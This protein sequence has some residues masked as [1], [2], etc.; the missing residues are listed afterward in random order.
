M[1][2]LRTLGVALTGLTLAF[3]ANAETG[4][5]SDTVLFGQI[6]AL[7]GPAARLG[8]GVQSGILAAFAEAN[9]A[10]GVHGRQLVLESRDDG[11]EPDR[12]VEH[13]NSMIEEDKYFSLIGTVGTPTNK[14]LQ[15][16]ATEAGFPLIGPFTGAGFLRNPELGNLYNVRGSYDA[17]AEQ[18]IAHLVEEL[19][20]TNIA[21]LYQD[22]SFGRAGLSGVN[23]ALTKRGM[24]LAAEG[25]Y[26]RN[27]T[28]VKDALVS[29]MAVN[30]QAVVMV[31]VYKP[32]GEF[33][34]LS[35]SYEFTPTFVT[36]SFVG[37]QALADELWPEGAG[38]I[39]SQVVPF[40]WDDSI[41]IV[42]D[43]QAALLAQD[44]FAG[45]GFVTL[46]GY[47]IGRLAI[48]A[49]EDAGQDLTRQGF[50]DA[51]SNMSA[52]DMGGIELSFSKTDNQ[53][54]DTIFMTRLLPDGFFE[55]M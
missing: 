7:D 18:W 6:A 34:K 4:V 29:L 37:S 15:P 44:P 36:I 47:I 26:T 9:A 48:A 43:Y 52:L 54:L 25:T 11:Y 40:P 31:G 30:P 19:G 39:I 24:Q 33:I 28:D 22:D 5:S 45:P 51:L 55:P 2:V 35:R 13:I 42:K 3:S 50:L 32:I 16:I 49:L 1:K 10:G 46:E 14:V 21:I 41:Q 17:E 23:K 8:L 38:V 12:S 27:T 53:G 20:Y